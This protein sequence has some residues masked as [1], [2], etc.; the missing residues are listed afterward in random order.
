MFFK[1]NLIFALLFT[2]G[3]VAYGQS[4]IFLTQQWFSRINMNPAATGNSNNVDVFLLNRQ[5]WVGF[6]NAPRTTIL[7]A[8]SYFNTIQS[9][10]GMSLMLDKLGVSYQT[11]NALLSYAYHID[12]TED[13][14][15]SL[16]LSGGLYNSHWDPRKNSFSEESSLDDLPEKKT[17]INP[18]V[19]TGLELNAYGITLG[20]SITHLLN[21]KL[22]TGKPGREYYSYMRYRAA[23]DKD[24]DIAPGIMYRINNRSN[25]FDFTI[26]GYYQ[27]KYW[28]GLSFRPNNAFAVMLGGE[29]SM[30]RLGYA[31]DHSVGATS[32]LAANTHEIMLSVRFQKP[33]KGRKTTRFFD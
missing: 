28:A 5:Q 14:L 10:L 11:V 20:A 13:V 9:G 25:F 2:V 33:Q 22:E 4:D 16:G 12:I 8:H 19:N 1:R 18:D 24:F 30:F 23:I 31:Y 32:S 26:T 17:L 15:M 27:K 3:S 6:S 7:N 29:Y 21:S